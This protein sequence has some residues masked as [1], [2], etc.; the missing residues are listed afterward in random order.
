MNKPGFEWDRDLVETFSTIQYLGGDRTY[1][2]VRGPVF[3]DTKKG[4]DKELSDF[5]NVNFGGPSSF[6]LKKNVPDHTIKSGTVKEYVETFYAF[7]ENSKPS[8]E[9]IGPLNR[10]TPVTLANDGTALKPGLEYDSKSQTLVGSTIEI[11]LDYVKANPEPNIE[12]LK[13]SMV[14]DASVS[15]LST[16]DAKVS[17]PVSVDYVPKG[18]DGEDMK[19]I[20]T[21]RIENVQMCKAC[22]HDIETDQHVLPSNAVCISKCA[23]C[24]AD[25]KVCNDC[26]T[27]GHTTY[28]P[29]LRRCDKC[30]I[31]GIKCEKNVVL[32]VILDCE[33]KNKQAMQL[34]EKDTH[35][36]LTSCI[37]DVGHLGKSTKGSWGNWFIIVEGERTSLVLLRTLRDHAEPNVKGTLR[38][39]LTLESVRNKD[40]QAV[41]SVCRLTQPQ[42][43]QCLTQIVAVVHT[44]LPETYKYWKSNVP[45]LYPHPIAI[46]T[47]PPG[48]LLILD[49]GEVEGDGKLLD[50]RLHYP[51]DVTVLR[52]DLVSPCSISYAAGICYYLDGNLM[53][54]KCQGITKQVQV[55]VSSLRTKHEISSYLEMHGLELDG[56]MTTLRERLANYFKPKQQA[57]SGNIVSLPKVT[58]KMTAVLA[59]SEGESVS[60]ITATPS[61]TKCSGYANEISFTYAK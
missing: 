8:G 1:N 9:I 45:G 60:L 55:K 43:I 32:L 44:L 5:S 49:K 46:C 61:C 41:D 29:E 58:A 23:V 11:D 2:F 10:F 50:M 56:N 47:G 51:C 38:K 28:I 54:V 15:F 35:M 42:V 27:K 59:K 19:N 21:N 20:L 39:L 52:K 7:S 30:V 33:E 17:L 25:K 4:G 18:Q 13:K 34:I 31:D 40:R 36:S 3:H 14:V 16:L 12:E 24:V 6:T 26:A 53:E 37:P 48:H 22:V 57:I